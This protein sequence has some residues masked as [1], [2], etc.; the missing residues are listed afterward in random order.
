[1]V[2]HSR[3]SENCQEWVVVFVLDAQ[4]GPAQ[5]AR[6]FEGSYDE[7]VSNCHDLLGGSPVSVHARLGCP[8]HGRE[9]FFCSDRIALIYLASAEEF[10]ECEDHE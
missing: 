7:L 2:T 5:F 1:M 9:A 8:W 10:E 6:T 4:D 3:P